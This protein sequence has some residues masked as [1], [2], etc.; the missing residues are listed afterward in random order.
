M[1]VEKEPEEDKPEVEFEQEEETQDSPKPGAE[2]SE[3]GSES[4]EPGSES[5]E[6]GSESSEPGAESSEPGAES[7]EP[8]K[9][10]SE[11]DSPKEEQ[12]SDDGSLYSSLEKSASS[13]EDTEKQEDE[14]SVLD[15]SEPEF[16]AY[17]EEEHKKTSNL[18]R[19]LVVGFLLLVLSFYIYTGMLKPGEEDTNLLVYEGQSILFR[20]LLSECREVPVFPSS[21]ELKDTVLSAERVIVSFDPNGDARYALGVHEIYKILSLLGVEASYA[22]SAPCNESVQND[23]SSCVEGVP[24]IYV[25]DGTSQ[26]P[27]VSLEQLNS[28][29]VNSIAPG[30]III[31]GVD[32]KGFDAAVCA[33][34][35]AILGVV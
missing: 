2:S 12:P 14:R 26:V 27:V 30:Q 34:D 7:S 31:S 35:L 20:S 9:E 8:V 22:Y 29:L 25:S 17:K 23:A 15:S 28:T 11:K 21:S 24:L 33:F 1:S 10:G 5:S 6:P 3:P 18:G 16:E 19:F 32:A 13:S 4:S